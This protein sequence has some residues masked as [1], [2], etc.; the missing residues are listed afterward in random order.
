MWILHTDTLF[1]STETRFHVR[2]VKLPVETLYWLST[3]QNIGLL[4]DKQPL[5][6]CVAVLAE[7]LTVLPPS[8]VPSLDWVT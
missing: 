1:C 3:A 7:V 4:N 5:S 2:K 8:S 6:V